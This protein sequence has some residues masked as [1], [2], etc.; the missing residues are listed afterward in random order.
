MQN[1]RL[2]DV[3]N[4]LPSGAKLS[5]TPEFER[6]AGRNLTDVSILQA[7]SLVIDADYQDKE[8]ELSPDGKT[9]KVYA[10]GLWI[11]WPAFTINSKE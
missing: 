2:I 8:A 6:A 1:G 4:H 10:G 9:V 5:I 11:P 7:C 3:I